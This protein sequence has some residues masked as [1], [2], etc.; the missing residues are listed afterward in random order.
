MPGVVLMPGD[1][2]DILW[3]DGDPRTVDDPATGT[4]PGI[5]AISLIG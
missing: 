2:P 4:G 1:R 5:S 3:P